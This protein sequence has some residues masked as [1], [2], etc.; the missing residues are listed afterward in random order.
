MALIGIDCRFA[1]LSVGLGTYTRNIVS[2]LVSTS[3]DSFVL[4]VRSVD[5]QWLNE[6][7]SKNFEVHLANFP[8]YSVKEQLF[9]PKI[10][11]KSTAELLYSPHFNIPLFCPVKTVI[12]VHDLILHRYPN[13]ASFIK[14]LAYRLVFKNAVTNAKHIIA[15]SNF[16]QRELV[17]LYGELLS[18]K[19]TVVTEGFDASFVPT[20]NSTV[21]DFYDLKPGYFLYVGTA[22]QHKNVQMLID[23][24]A[25]SGVSEPLII[26]SN[27]KEVDQ[28]QMCD[29]VRILLGVDNDE[30]PAL[31]SAAGC[32]VTAS[33]YEGFCLP[34]LEA[35]ACGRPVIASDVSAIPE[36]A[37]EHALLIGL[38]EEHLISAFKDPPTVCDPLE[39]KHDWAISAKIISDILKDV[40]HG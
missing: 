9:F 6:I 26:V 37:G 36:I 29:G 5:E 22:K 18:D 17:S 8:H 27:G 40:L 34:I 4:F 28:L 11:R 31:Y 1:S 15:V 30:L 35:R 13:A 32:F 23:A 21:L 10:I 3:Q 39:G 12:T 24:Y 33:A 25:K 14:R 16:T 19:T 38:S 20:S 7:N 2:N